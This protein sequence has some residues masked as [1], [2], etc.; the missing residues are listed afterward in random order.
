[1]LYVLFMF[2]CWVSS[3]I[4]GFPTVSFASLLHSWRT[5]LSKVSLYRCGCSTSG[6]RPRSG[7]RAL[8]VEL[9]MSPSKSIDTL[10][11]L[12]S[13]CHWGAQ[14]H[15]L[16]YNSAS[17]CDH[18]KEHERTSWWICDF[19]DEGNDQLIYE[20]TDYLFR[21]FSCSGRIRGFLGEYHEDSETSY[22]LCRWYLVFIAVAGLMILTPSADPLC[23]H[24]S[25]IKFFSRGQGPIQE[26]WPGPH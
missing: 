19:I 23:L 22:F 17:V 12:K 13:P 21:L 7:D 20:L 3:T 24:D 15:P 10:A 11:D 8:E 1:M 2:A 5:S 25:E 9:Y 18:G 4:I 26:P 6:F 16:P 14:C